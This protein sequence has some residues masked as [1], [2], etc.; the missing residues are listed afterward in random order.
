MTFGTLELSELRSSQKE[1]NTCNIMQKWLLNK[2]RVG[3]HVGGMQEVPSLMHQV[4]MFRCSMEYDQLNR[5]VL[6]W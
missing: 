1:N 5:S 4:T 3:V 6:L 2:F